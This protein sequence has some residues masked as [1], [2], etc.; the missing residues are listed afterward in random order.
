V[1]VYAACAAIV[2]LVAVLTNGSIGRAVIVAAFFFFAATGWSWMH[3][4]RKIRER[5]RREAV[6]RKMRAS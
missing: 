3:W 1:L 6:E 4:R 2:V 5:D